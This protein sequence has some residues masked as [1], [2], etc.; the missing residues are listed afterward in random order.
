MGYVA[1]ALQDFVG[2]KNAVAIQDMIQH[3]RT[4][5][6]SMI[7]TASGIVMLV[8]GASGVFIQLKDAL[9][10]IWGIEPAPL[11][12]WGTIKQTFFSVTAVLGTGFLLM[13]SLI[14][15]AVLT[16]INHYF[17]SILP[18][19]EMLWNAINQGVSLAV[20]AG[21]F[22]LMFRYLPD[23]RVAW[24]DVAVGAV[25]TAV[26]FTAGKYALGLYIAKA[27]IAT[28]FGTAGSLA[29]VLIWV[30]YS[31]QILFFGAELTKVYA[32]RFGAPIEPTEG[33]RPLVSIT[34]AEDATTAPR[35]SGPRDRLP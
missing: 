9:N 21:I 18:G 8:L 1:N 5:S 13:V 11:G 10:T 17:G 4:P 24:R 30:Y 23:A 27:G 19:G 25:V 20:F 33:A 28:P 26:L 35:I 15:S 12:V 2:R 22:A 32:N 3:A 31:A 14:I 16:A 29:V 6:H 34:R 7:S